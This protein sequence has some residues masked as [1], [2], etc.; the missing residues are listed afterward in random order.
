MVLGHSFGEYAALVAAG[1]L[2]DVDALFIAGSRAE[3]LTKTCDSG[4]SHKML[5]VGDIAL[6][7]RRP[8]A[9]RP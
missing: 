6:A 8:A 9:Q 5:A 2:S 4:C 1:A 7:A 3:L